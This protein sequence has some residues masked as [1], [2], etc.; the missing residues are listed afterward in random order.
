[1]PDAT[2]AIISVHPDYARAILAGTKTVEL[3]RRIPGLS[4]GTRLWIYATRPIKAV[5]GLVTIRGVAR[6]HPAALWRKH[7][8]GTGLDHTAFKTYFN[9]SRLG[10]AI[11]LE[12]A[13]PVQPITIKQLQ[14]IRDRFHPPQV[15]TRLSSLEA[16]ALQMLAS[17]ES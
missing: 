2:D 12:A 14:R 3:R 13:K 8:A 6:A 16:K 9:G 4:P 5:V 17:W 1:V 11:L 7:H 10:V 15:V